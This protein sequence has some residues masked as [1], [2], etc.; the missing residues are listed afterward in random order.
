MGGLGSLGGAR[1]VPTDTDQLL[2]PI[3]EHDDSHRLALA[4]FELQAEQLA[5]SNRDLSEFAYIAAHDLRAPLAA[6]AG[7]AELLAR[8]SGSQLDAQAQR[9][10]AAVLAKVGTMGRMLDD[11][12][13]YCHAAKTTE[14]RQVIDCTDVLGEVLEYLAPEIVEAEAYVSMQSLGKVTGERTQLVQL[15]QNLIANAL[16]FRRPGCRARIDVSVR[17]FGDDRVYSVTD[18]GIGV[19]HEDRAEI[20]RMFHQLNQRSDSPGTGIG[21][22]ICK[23][24][25]ERHCGRIWVDDSPGGGLCVSFSLPAAD[26]TPLNAGQAPLAAATYGRST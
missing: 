18:E 17:R 12:L 19:P 7:S 10:L 8:R 9:Y 11:I 13:A 6:L 24:I 16:K 4:E 22:S 23:R 20:F 15:F 1:T 26:P 14:E 3:A 2:E 25:V 5:R 21:L